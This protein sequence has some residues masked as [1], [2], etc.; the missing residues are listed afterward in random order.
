M[1]DDIERRDVGAAL[2][3]EIRTRRLRVM[4]DFASAWNAHDVSALMACMTEDC[5]YDASAGPD[6]WGRRY[7]GQ[8]AVRGAFVAFFERAPDAQWADP[9]HTLTDEF[10]I[11]RWRFIATVAGASV[12]ADGLDLLWFGDDDRIAH[13]SPYR[14]FEPLS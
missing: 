4:D 10:G 9:V 8:S 11:T 14:K 3:P 5:V 2:T 12:V 1:D 13:K 6:P 7:V